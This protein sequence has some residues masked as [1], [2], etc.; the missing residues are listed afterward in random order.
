MARLV[1]WESEL[2]GGIDSYDIDIQGE[3]G[4]G[5]YRKNSVKWLSAAKRQRQ[6]RGREYGNP[7]EAAGV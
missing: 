3:P 2:C 1:S 7:R 5:L 4:S 6:G